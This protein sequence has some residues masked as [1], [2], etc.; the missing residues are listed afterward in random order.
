MKFQLLQNEIFPLFLYFIY[1]FF[2]IAVGG[3]ANF[4][5]KWT[6]LTLCGLIQPA[7]ALPLIV[8]KNNVD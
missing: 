3:N 7:T 8:D 1:I 4:E 5:M 6:C 2:Y